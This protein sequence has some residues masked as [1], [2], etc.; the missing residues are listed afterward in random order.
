MAG[1]REKLT[2]GY[3]HLDTL[4]QE[5]AAFRDLD[6]NRV[7]QVRDDESDVVIASVRLGNPPVRLGI[8]AG[9]AIQ[10]FRSA[11][12]HLAHAAG[13]R[14]RPGATHPNFPI[15][16][17]EGAFLRSGTKR[18]E[19]ARDV[20]VDAFGPDAAACMERHQPYHS[21][22]PAGHSLA[23]LRTLSNFDKHETIQVGYAVVRGIGIVAIDRE[24]RTDRAAL[25][26]VKVR[27]DPRI[28][29]GTEV[30]RFGVV[31][32]EPNVDV[33][34]RVDLTLGI[35]FAGELQVGRDGLLELG[36]AVGE[37]V[38]EMSGV[39]IATHQGTER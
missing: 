9:E 24:G 7:V 29:D 12:D 30:A 18:P 3:E 13:E 36:A 11:L 25:R 33:G 6:E 19:S 31:A 10:Q 39:L 23:L 2:R 4:E 1:I 8:L 21:E 35:R 14:R 27:A 20:C 34:S 37:I 17:T 32:L 38:D 26:D 5:I 16:L 15:Y 28:E 22:R